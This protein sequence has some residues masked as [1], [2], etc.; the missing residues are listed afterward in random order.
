VPHNRGTRHKP[1]YVGMASYKGHTKWVG[2][3]STLA[4][5][6]AA[7]RQRLAELREE[8]DGASRWRAPTVMKFAGAVIEA[9][10]R[11][12]MRWPDGQRAQKETGRRDSSVRRLREGLKP[13]LRDFGERRLDSFT[14]DEAL[15]WAL[16]QGRHV[17][18]AVRQSSTTPSSV[19]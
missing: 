2:T 13:F 11:I 5:Y 14:R 4:A 15:T 10:G 6:K 18:Q 9:D 17:Q 7:E 3:H 8:V 19:S 1:K 16:S 12:V